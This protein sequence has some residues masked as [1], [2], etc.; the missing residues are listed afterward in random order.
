MNPIL[1][2]SE[3][4]SLTQPQRPALTSKGAYPAQFLPPSAFTYAGV[5]Y[6]FPQYSKAGNDNVLCR[7]QKIVV[8]KGQYSKVCF[9]T[10]SQSGLASGNFFSHYDDGSPHSSAVYVPA[11][12]TWPYPSGG[13]IIFP[14]YL[15]RSGIN[16][17]RS[18]IY[19]VCDWLDSKKYLT[20]LT[21][22]NI[23]KGSD[24]GPL[25]TPV[26]TRLHIFALS[27]IS[28]VAENLPKPQLR[29]EYARTSQ[30]W[31]EGT[32][33]TQI[34]EAVISNIGNEYIMRGHSV[35]VSITSP[36]IHTVRSA[37]IKR[38]GPGD[39]ATVEIGVENFE[40]TQAGQIG[41]ATVI[42]DGSDASSNSYTFDATYGISPYD[43]TYESIY[44]HESPTWFKQA[45]YGIFIHWGFYSVPAWGNV[46]KNETYAEWYAF[47]TPSFLFTHMG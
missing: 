39:Q 4:C 8:P 1:M 28:A 41:P 14:H 33:Q 15:S 27:L 42:V 2:D 23:S 24:E 6:S 22:P 40:G 45:K 21:L 30:K 31:I 47:H 19:Q 13:D 17:N 10:A 3:V 12:W 37:S 29:I 36:G 11:W 18:S 35:S 38:L 16:Y 20:S 46:G 34:V 32:N 25:G 5:N 26:G 7:G 43:R 9:F 44:S